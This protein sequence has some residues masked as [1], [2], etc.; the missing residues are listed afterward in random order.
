MSVTYE[1]VV[2]RSWKFLEI[3]PDVERADGRDVALEAQLLEALKNVVALLL[4]VPLERKLLLLNVLGIQQG[5]SGQLK[6]MVRATVEER[7][8]LRERRDE[9]HWSNYPADTPAR[10]APVL[11][12]ANE[13][14][15]R[16]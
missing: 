6:R 8:G 4:E 3:E 7:A 12:T 2:N 14:Y 9:V 16:V 13:K 5:D 15:R 10:K 11:S 1:A